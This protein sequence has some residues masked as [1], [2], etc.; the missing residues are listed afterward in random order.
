M[1]ERA[2]AEG[3]SSPSAA[4]RAIV[5]VALMGSVMVGGVWWAKNHGLLGP[6]AQAI[7]AAWIEPLG[8]WAPWAFLAF[9]ILTIAIGIPTAP[10]TMVGGVIFGLPGGIL[11]NMAGATI[12]AAIPLL[13]VRYFGRELVAQQL[14]GR[15]AMWDEAIA[16]KGFWAILVL[17]LLPVVPFGLINFGS[18][19]SRIGLAS[20]LWATLLGTIPGVLIYTY[21][22]VAATEGSLWGMAG[23]F[24]V[25]AVLALAPVILHGPSGVAQSIK[26]WGEAPPPKA[27][28]GIPTTTVPMLEV[29]S[30]A[31]EA[32]TTT[33]EQLEALDRG[34][35]N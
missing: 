9:K 29:V 2:K 15:W 19:L 8:P 22:G 23:A 27:M 4:W 6:Q 10:V 33:G 16:R 12:G 11:L 3:L 17:R 18:G 14:K 25:L 7:M 32:P 26:A 13:L 5:G 21:I 20:Y 31:A 1:S 35:S 24:A 28:E 30:E 34:S